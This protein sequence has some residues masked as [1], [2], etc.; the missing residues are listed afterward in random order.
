[1]SA[2]QGTGE[3]KDSGAKENLWNR[4]WENK[5]YNRN[6]RLGPTLRARK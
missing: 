1:M 3:K 5:A 2:N 4:N 6:K